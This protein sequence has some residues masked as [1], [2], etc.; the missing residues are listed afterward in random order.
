MTCIISLKFIQSQLQFIENQTVVIQTKH[1]YATQSKIKHGEITKIKFFEILQT[2]F[3]ISL[4]IILVL[5]PL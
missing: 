5:E 3:K 2:V 1:H 4:S